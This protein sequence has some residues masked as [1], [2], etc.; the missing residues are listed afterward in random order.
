MAVTRRPP[1]GMRKS[2]WES[3]G[4]FDLW[5]PLLAPSQMLLR[6]IQGGKL[7]DPR[8]RAS[9]F[10]AYERELNRAEARHLIA[11]I[12]AIARRTPIALGCYCEDEKNCHRSV[13]RRVIEEHR[14]GR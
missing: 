7:D 13:L 9:F 10:A 11:L 2:E 12:V 5:F 1:R 8:K 6:R 4:Q 3:R 14:A